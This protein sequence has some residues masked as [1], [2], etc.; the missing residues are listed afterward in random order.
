M[1][2]ARVYIRLS[3]RC[4]DQVTMHRPRLISNMS[5]TMNHNTNHRLVINQSK[6]IDSGDVTECIQSKEKDNRSKKKITVHRTV[7]N[8]RQHG[9][10]HFGSSRTATTLQ[11]PLRKS[12][13]LHDRPRKT[14]S[15]PWSHLVE[16][17]QPGS[18][19]EDR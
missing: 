2:L 9:R 15:Y 13:L 12:A 1:I 18:R 8:N 4:T 6:S 17:S 11:R 7:H 14:K 3:K 19:L 5:H 10:I 16:R